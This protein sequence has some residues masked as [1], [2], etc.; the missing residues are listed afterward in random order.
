MPLRDNLG[1]HRNRNRIAIIG[2]RGIPAAY[3][4][5]E[6][7][8]EV[9]APALSRNGFQ[10]YVSCESKGF[11][12][13][14]YASYKG[15]RLVY[16]PVIGTIR[17]L[18]EVILYDALAASWAA[19]SVDIIYMLAY[20]SIPTLIL[21]RLCGKTVI[22]NVDGVEWKRPKY[23]RLLRFILHA[24]EIATT[25]IAN[26]VVVDSHTLG[27]YYKRNYG[28]TSVYLPY[29]ITEI[30]ALGPGALARFGVRKDEYYLVIGRLIPDNNI[31]IIIEGF[32]RSHSTKKLVIVGPL[33]RS[34]YVR[35]LLER[36][37]ERTLFVGGVY[38]PQLQRTLRH[39]CYAY[40]HGHEMGGT[41]PSL[42]EALSCGNLILALDVD[43]NREVAEDCAIYFKKQAD[44]LAEKID[45][46]ERGPVPLEMKNGTNV[47]Y[48]EKYSAE[49]AVKAFVEFLSQIS[50]P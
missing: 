18:S 16:F 3:G 35:R 9:I 11:K 29:G 40:I 19:L 20:T 24:F 34:G 33:L 47:L 21:A 31:D 10:A 14:P 38:E 37:N 44:D 46:L 50:S 39:N 6:T 43:F 22:V 2:S 41:N 30:Q 48:H 36:R 25:R 49:G 1:T 7:I 28:V 32:A 8:V 4:G 12:R 15:V 13:R 23:N 27:A 45:L 42:V 17:N 26:Y 5:F